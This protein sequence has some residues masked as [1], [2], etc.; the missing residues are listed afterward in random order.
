[1]LS[2]SLSWARRR[3]LPVHTFAGR[4]SH[5]G[6][7]RRKRRCHPNQ[8]PTRR[9]CCCSGSGG[10]AAGQL[11]GSSSSS[12]GRQPHRRRQEGAQRWVL[13][14][15]RC[16]HTLLGALLQQV[17]LAPQDRG[18][19]IGCNVGHRGPHDGR[20]GH[21]SVREGDGFGQ[22]E[23]Q[24]PCLRQHLHGRCHQA[25]LGSCSHP[26][27]GA[28]VEYEAR[29]V[30][31][32]SSPVHALRRPSS[33]SPACQ[34]RPS[35]RGESLLRE[36]GR[37]VERS[38]GREIERSSCRGDNFVSKVNRIG[39]EPKYRARLLLT[40]DHLTYGARAPGGERGCEL[41]CS[42]DRR[43]RPGCDSLY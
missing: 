20:A 37:E 9:G 17:S 30:R 40:C 38:R 8:T 3:F 43:R 23:R 12:S 36:R 6:C 21:G 35:W 2:P 33:S 10:G 15:A 22:A 28:H 11:G 4:A 27:P 24:P 7:C 41:D 32:G 31:T 29:G 19:N 39:G 25:S 26:P 1:M 5:A 18:H 13:Q 34:H 42:T 16:K 14:H